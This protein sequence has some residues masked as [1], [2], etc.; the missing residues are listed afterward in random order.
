[1]RK[2]NDIMAI[3]IFRGGSSSVLLRFVAPI[4]SKRH[5]EALL[6]LFMHSV[7]E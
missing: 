3:T 4:S 2:L 1:M 6:L 5:M 7:I